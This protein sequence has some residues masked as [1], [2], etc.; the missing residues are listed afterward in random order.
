MNLNGDEL[1]KRTESEVMKRV[2]F[3]FDETVAGFQQPGAVSGTRRASYD[4]WAQRASEVQSQ[5]A[6]LRLG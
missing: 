1:M 2:R 6:E 4:S 5:F 3:F